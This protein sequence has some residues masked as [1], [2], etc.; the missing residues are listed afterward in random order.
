MTR[1]LAKKKVRTDNF[2]N[3]DER[4]EHNEMKEAF[5]HTIDERNMETST[6]RERDQYLEVMEG[7]SSSESIENVKIEASFIQNSNIGF[8]E[9]KL[10]NQK[11]RKSVEIDED[12]I[13]K[14]NVT[15]S[16]AL[17][18]GDI[19]E[20]VLPNTSSS[21]AEAI[22]ESVSHQNE[23]QVSIHK[24]QSNS[25]ESE[26]DKEDTSYYLNPY[27]S[28]NKETYRFAYDIPLTIGDESSSIEY[29]EEHC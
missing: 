20:G 12:K 10:V 28:L 8:N 21:L 26:D 27:V 15:K 25:S 13:G 24:D 4:F 6:L 9:S 16:A 1:M 19:N 14:D 5:Y 22:L 3:V 2:E 11:N 18:D 23:T 17:K 29:N 7:S